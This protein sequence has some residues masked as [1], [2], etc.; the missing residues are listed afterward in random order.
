VHNL[1]PYSELKAYGQFILYTLRNGAYQ[2]EW[3]RF[4]ERFDDQRRVLLVTNK[5]ALPRLFPFPPASH[6]AQRFGLPPAAPVL[7]LPVCLA[8]LRAAIQPKFWLFSRLFW[9]LKLEWL[10]RKASP[11]P[12]SLSYRLTRTKHI[13]TRVRAQ[14]PTKAPTLNHQPT[15]P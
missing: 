2:S 13:V 11:Y 1:Q 8:Q 9:A 3:Y 15:K 7:S 14:T 10:G 4:H 6:K 12:S 5:Y